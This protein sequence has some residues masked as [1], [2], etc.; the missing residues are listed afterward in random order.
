M[1]IIAYIQLGLYI[2]L[3]ALCI[4]CLILIKKIRKTL[5]EGIKKSEEILKKRTEPP[6]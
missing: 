5:K 2:I 6:N 3:L 1:E 4:Y